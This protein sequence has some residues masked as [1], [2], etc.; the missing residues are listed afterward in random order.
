[1]TLAVQKISRFFDPSNTVFDL[2]LLLIRWPFKMHSY[3]NQALLIADCVWKWKL[4][5]VLKQAFCPTS[6]CGGRLKC[7]HLFSTPYISKGFRQL[8]W[9]SNRTWGAAGAHQRLLLCRWSQFA[10]LESHSISSRHFL[11]QYPAKSL[12]SWAFKL[13]WPHCQNPSR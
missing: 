2:F 12:T 9:E 7:N 5:P 8:R 1:M 3:N 11:A 10:V 13:N 4:L 6:L